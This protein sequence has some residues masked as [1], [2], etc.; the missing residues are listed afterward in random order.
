MIEVTFIGP[1]DSSKCCFYYSTPITGEIYLIE[2]FLVPLM[3]LKDT[4]LSYN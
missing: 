3:L 1:L 4:V 2:R